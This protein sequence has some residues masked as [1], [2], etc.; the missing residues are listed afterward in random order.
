MVGILPGPREPKKN[1]LTPLVIELQEAW[2]DGFR[3]LSPEDSPVRIKLDLS[4]VTCDI[5][6][7]RKVCGFLS[8][9]AA[10]HCKN[11]GVSNT[12]I[13]LHTHGVF[14]HFP[15]RSVL[16]TPTGWCDIT[17]TANCVLSTPSFVAHAQ[18]G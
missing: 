4:C 11:S 6:A 2:Q 7:S 18:E 17:P 10:L 15:L 8:H 14:A 13:A 3:V 16:S 1:Y 5:P 12:P 9:N